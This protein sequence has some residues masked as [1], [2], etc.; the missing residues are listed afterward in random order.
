MDEMQTE[1][2]TRVNGGSD[3]AGDKPL[4]LHKIKPA[5]IP[6]T[7]LGHLNTNTSDP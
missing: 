7:A 6:G 4:A 1:C 3:S 2:K 5:S